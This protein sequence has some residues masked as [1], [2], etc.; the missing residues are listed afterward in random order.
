MSPETSGLDTMRPNDRQLLDGLQ[1]DMDMVGVQERI[2]R[3]TTQDPA[4]YIKQILLATGKLIEWQT[5]P[6]TPEIW[7]SCDTR[8]FIVTLRPPHPTV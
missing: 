2:V 3:R 1:A 7:D 6:E 4:G 8:C 5:H